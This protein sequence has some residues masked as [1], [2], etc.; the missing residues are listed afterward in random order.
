MQIG[1]IYYVYPINKWVSFKFIAEQH[2]RELRKQ[3]NVVTVDEKAF[4]TIVLTATVS[5]DPLFFLHP[6]FYPFE[7]YKKKVFDRTHIRARIIAV[8]VS[9]SDRISE[10]AVNALNYAEAIIVPSNFSR[11]AL[12]SSSVEKP[13]Y[14]VPHG[15]TKEFLTSPKSQPKRFAEL[16]KYKEKRNKKLIQ[17]WLLHSGYRKGEDLLYAI[18]NELVNERDDVALVVRR[19]LSIDVYESEIDTKTIK[20]TFSIS[21]S[22]LDD[23]EIIE[24]MDICDIYLLTSRGGGFE[25]PTLQAL[26]RKEIAFG[27]K[28]GAWED[29]LPEFCLIPSVKSGPVL[30]DNPIHI[31]CGVEM[32]TDKAVDILHQVLDNFEYWKS[33][34]EQYVQSVIVPNYSWEAIGKRLIEITKMHL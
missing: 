13:I 8:D 32:L 1:Q 3:F 22:Y 5:A 16:H 17:C 18:F 9:D 11:N 20:P 14:V 29:F 12:I 25:H 31:G 19:P 21:V 26:A 7:V 33:R 24:L 10:Y 15:C 28:G 34:I 23:R 4:P 2:V 27:A 6:F 30:S